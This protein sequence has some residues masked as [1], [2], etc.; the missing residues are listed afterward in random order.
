ML[1]LPAAERRDELR[2]HIA[3][4]LP[5]NQRLGLIALLLVA[6]VA[7]QIFAHWLWVGALLLLAATLLGIVKG[8]STDIRDARIHK[9]EW[10][11]CTQKEFDRVTSLYDR[12]QQWDKA[13]VDIT[14]GRG[15]LGLILA[16]GAVA[17]VYFFFRSLDFETEGVRY[18]NLVLIDAIVL[19]VPHWVTGVRTILKRDQ[20]IIKM[21]IYD[22]IGRH[23]EEVKAKTEEL[24]PMLETG[25]SAD[26]DVPTDA[27]LMI[28]FHDTDPEFLGLQGQTSINSVQGTDYPYF[29]CVLI[30]RAG[31]DL[32]GKAHRSGKLRG[33]RIVYEFDRQGK[34]DDAVDVLVVRQAT[35]KT[36]GYHTKPG[37]AREIFHDALTVARAVL[38]PQ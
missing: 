27:K 37:R 32:K 3:K 6:G 36:S 11:A 33:Q 25:R 26:G 7:L 18:E 23:F 22:L 30:A 13:W 5:Y 14:C 10:R 35:T 34:G 38:E 19:L 2:F 9:R 4:F 17:G 21:R 24:R 20:L 28:H 29:Y 15:F 16:A 1:L 31:F 8:Y 12:T